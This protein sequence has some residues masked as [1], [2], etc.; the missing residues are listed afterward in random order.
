MTDQE[1]LVAAHT[2]WLERDGTVYAAPLPD[3]PPFVLAGPGAAIWLALTDGGTL[4]EVTRRV[5]DDV[6]S[7]VEVVAADVAAFV[8]GLVEAGLVV[9]RPA[10]AVPAPSHD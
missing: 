8:A 9:Q 1:L 6:G 10:P 3:G 4:D 2:A 5:A 7:P